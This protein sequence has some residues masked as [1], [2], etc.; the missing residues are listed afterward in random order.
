MIEGIPNWLAIPVLIVGISIG[1]GIIASILRL[2]DG[3]NS[4]P[5]Q[6]DPAAGISQERKG[7]DP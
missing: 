5:T 2:F 1:C 6:E 4:N 7:P 3:H